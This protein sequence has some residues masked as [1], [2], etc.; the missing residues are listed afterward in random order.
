[1][2]MAVDSFNVGWDMSAGVGE[3]RDSVPWAHDARVNAA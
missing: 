2:A 1:M 3:D